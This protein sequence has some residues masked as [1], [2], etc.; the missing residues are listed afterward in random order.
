MTRQWLARPED[1]C[2]RHLTGEHAEAHSFVTKMEK[3]QSLL[4]FR[5]QS[6]FFGALFVKA[7]HDY[8]ASLLPNHATPLVV[9]ESMI[10]QYPLVMPTLE[11]VEKST[12]D[13][14]SRCSEC[15]RNF[16]ESLKIA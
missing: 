1:M 2:I 13:L 12:R 5:V 15:S 16:V 11:D 6:M 8:I 10:E 14:L 4:G 9:T 7:R 3:G